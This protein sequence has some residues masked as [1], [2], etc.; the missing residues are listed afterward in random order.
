MSIITKESAGYL[1]TE[2]LF[3]AAALPIL[4]ITAVITA[5]QS[6]IW[7]VR[8]LQR[9]H[10]PADKREFYARKCEDWNETI[11]KSNA[12]YAK[13][14]GW[15][16]VPG[17]IYKAFQTQVAAELFATSAVGSAGA[18][19]ND[20]LQGAAR[21]LPYPEAGRQ[22][23]PEEAQQLL[24]W[25]KRGWAGQK[26]QAAKA[27]AYDPPP[28]VHPSTVKTDRVVVTG[29]NGSRRTLDTVY[30]QGVSINTG[31]ESPEYGPTVTLFHGNMMACDSMREYVKFYHKRGI[32]VLAVTMGDYPGSDPVPGGITPES[33]YAD[34]QAAIQFVR[35][36]GVSNNCQLAHGLS[37]GGSLAAY[38]GENN[39][40]VHVVSDQSFTTFAECAG[41]MIGG[42][43]SPMV[44][45]V[46][47]AA[48]GGVQRRLFPELGV[49]E[50]LADSEGRISRMTG[51]LIVISASDDALMGNLPE[52]IR[53]TYMRTH[54]SAAAEGDAKAGDA[55]AKAK[56]TADER[57]IKIL[58]GHGTPFYAFPEARKQMERFLIKTGLM[59]ADN[60]IDLNS[61]EA[62]A[63]AAAVT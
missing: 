42:A 39:P 30:V 1:W 6:A 12:S 32:N 22:L 40:G 21:K 20:K 47:V 7:G 3:A 29:A 9:D 19:D 15:S 50:K 61:I 58:G 11:T 25:R 54:A 28:L 46:A 4:A 57:L 34:A 62:E 38:A 27:V 41:N 56:F 14:F 37:I 5:I 8:A 51:E 23:S 2:R 53:D 17:G 31:W 59:P 36:K 49:G 52:R 63:L 48:V 45:D 26:E 24:T 13:F 16:L 10:G 44:G 43:T 18:V 35:A 33:T 60:A 55:G